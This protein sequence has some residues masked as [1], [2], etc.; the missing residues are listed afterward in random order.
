MIL[1]EHISNGSAASTGSNALP[2]YALRVR[3]NYERVAAAHLRHRGIEEFAPTFKA[4]RQ[5]SD[6]KKQVDQFLFTG[7]V[8]CR[9][10]PNHRQLVATI[11]GAVGLV[12]FGNGPAL[13]PAEEIEAVQRITG[14]GL[15]VAPW[16]F[17]RVGQRV[18]IERGPLTGVEGILQ[19]IRKTF[20]LVVSVGLLQRSVSAELDRSWIRPLSE[21]RRLNM[22]ATLPVSRAS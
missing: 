6:R 2:W 15:L 5:W 13:I 14:S 12:G 8:F 9:L 10:D 4:E 18:V 21:S 20:R 1:G 16:P 19:E 7:Y 22:I 11:P 3:S 17:L